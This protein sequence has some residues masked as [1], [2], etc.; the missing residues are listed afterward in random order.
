MPYS[1]IVSDEGR[2]QYKGSFYT[3][4]NGGSAFITFALEVETF[5]GT[6]GY[7]EL[8]QEIVDRLASIPGL[9]PTNRS[10]SKVWSSARTVTPTPDE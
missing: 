10:A 6:Y 1:E 8:F 2:A 5:G 7:D 4:Q 3:T 9:D